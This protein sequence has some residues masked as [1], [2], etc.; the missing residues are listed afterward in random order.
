MGYL[1]THS[2][3]DGG[4]LKMKRKTI[5]SADVPV[6]GNEI[7]R[8]IVA[9]NGEQSE[10]NWGEI[11]HW[12]TVW[13]SIVVGHRVHQWA[14]H[15]TQKKNNFLSDLTNGNYLALTDWIARSV[16]NV[17]K[18]ILFSSISGSGIKA[19]FRRNVLSN[20]CLSMVTLLILLFVCFSTL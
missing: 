8:L 10:V 19:P 3:G 2:M 12:A 18:L 9:C 17:I 20:P 1:H 6:W 13:H 11:G 14:N 4:M 16:V 15:W 5:S 7:A